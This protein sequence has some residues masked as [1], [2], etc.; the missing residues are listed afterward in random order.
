MT[1][2]IIEAIDKEIATLQEARAIIAEFAAPT[3]PTAP[4]TAR[5]GR[6][7]GSKNAAKAVP[8]AINRGMTEEGR[9]RISAALKKRHAANRKAAQ[10]SVAS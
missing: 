5:R 9:A 8:V 3:I 1:N 4:T 10:K 7:K 2:S 6:P